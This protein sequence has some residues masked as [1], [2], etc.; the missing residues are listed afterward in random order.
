MISL[1]SILWIKKN[2]I[3][4]AKN[5]YSLVIDKYWY[6]KW[7]LSNCLFPLVYVATHSNTHIST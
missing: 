7:K 2:L 5:N 4:S 6:I 3:V 1:T